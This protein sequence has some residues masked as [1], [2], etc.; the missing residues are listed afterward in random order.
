MCPTSIDAADAVHL[1]A[2]IADDTSLAAGAAD[3]GRRSLLTNRQ[4]AEHLN[5]GLATFY[6]LLKQ[7]LLPPPIYVRPNTP[8]WV[9]SELDAA[10]ARLPRAY[11]DE[12]KVSARRREV[13]R[14]KQ[15]ETKA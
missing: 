5:V 6:N 7:R 9:A 15:E 14:R 10:I 3:P 12:W 11:P 2:M 8:R 13:L 4:S 1:R